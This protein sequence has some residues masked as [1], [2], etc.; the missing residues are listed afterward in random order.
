MPISLCHKCIYI[1]IPKCAGSA[2]ERV[3]Q[4]NKRNKKQLHGPDGQGDFLQHYTLL[5][6]ENYMKENLP[7]TDINSYYTFAIVRNPYSKLVSDFAWCKRWFKH[8]WLIADSQKVGFSSFE[9]Y[10]R[11]IQTVGVETWSHFRP[12][13]KFVEGA[14]FCNIFHLEKLKQC[15]PHI[16]T[17]LKLDSDLPMVN[18]SRHKPWRTYYTPELFAIVNELYSKDFELFGYKKIT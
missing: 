5:Q 17:E 18:R 12:Q 1:H 2:F 13:Y 14:M 9:E 16:K 7:D 15:Y 6:I 11:F 8:K 4:I 10:I 3:L